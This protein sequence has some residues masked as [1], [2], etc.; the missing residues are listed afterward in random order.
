AAEAQL[1]QVDEAFTKAGAQARITLSAR[2]KEL[3]A[4]L[5][6]A[7]QVKDSVQ[8]MRTVLSSQANG[9]TDM[10]GF[11]DRLERSGPE[12]LRTAQTQTGSKPGAETQA[13]PP[14]RPESAGI[15]ALIS[16]GVGSARTKRQLDDAI[17]ETDSLR[18]SLDQLRAPIVA[19]LTA[20]MRRSDA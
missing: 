20:A 14:F 4:E 18:K 5:N 10:L 12:G 2:R 3:V 1:A 13:G 11:V 16:E 19:N 8:N 6:F 9:G 15:L 7:K 17:A